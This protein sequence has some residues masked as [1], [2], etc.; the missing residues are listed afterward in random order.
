MQGSPHKKKV[1]VLDTAAFLAAVQ[2]LT[3]GIELYAPI[4]VIEEVKDFESLHR[5]HL[6]EAIERVRIEN[7][8]NTFASK[9]VE[10]A[11]SY[12]VLE[13]LSKTDLDV[14][15]LA[16]QLSSQGYEVIVLT[17]DYVLQLV[18]AK[19]GLGFRP[20]KTLGIKRR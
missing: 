9:A 6:T 15:A 5:L 4:T 7:P 12:G 13:K 10:I 1:L 19:L 14:F 16:L 2:L 17:D 18:L 11:K 3:Y 8:T 20:V